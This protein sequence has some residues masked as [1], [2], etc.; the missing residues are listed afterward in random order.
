MSFIKSCDNDIYVEHTE[1]KNGKNIFVMP[2][3][4]S[5]VTVSKKIP[6]LREMAKERGYGFTCFDYAGYGK[7]GGEPGE[8]QIEEWLQNALDVYDFVNTENNFIIG[9]SMGGFLMLAL[10]ILRPEKMKGL[11]G[12]M[13]GFGRSFARVRKDK[14]F[15]GDFNST[16]KIKIGSNTDP[17]YTFVD[18]KLDI[19]LPTFLLTSLGDEE[20]NY[21]SSISIS[22]SLSSKNT[23]VMI[24]KDTTHSISDIKDLRHVFDFIDRLKV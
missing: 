9:S 17:F 3:H 16:V 4:G 11:V 13:P 19:D 10:A 2:G 7:S 22:E 1:S 23:E 8:W 12:L 14:P 18:G 5:G 21:R 6:I 24:L 20:V 15:I